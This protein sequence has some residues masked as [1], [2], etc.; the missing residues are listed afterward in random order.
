MRGQQQAVREDMAVTEAR[1]R[2]ERV[3]LVA[4]GGAH[5][6]A[7][8]AQ[9]EAALGNFQSTGLDNPIIEELRDI[10]RAGRKILARSHEISR[11]L[12]L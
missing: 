4:A 5:V 6:Q 1:K 11:R 7:A 10:I 8:T 2:R 12:P 3:E 9:L